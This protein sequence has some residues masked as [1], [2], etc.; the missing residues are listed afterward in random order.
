[1]RGSS[2]YALDF[3]KCTPVLKIGRLC[4]ECHELFEGRQGNGPAADGA[5]Q[6]GEGLVLTSYTLIFTTFPRRVKV[7]VEF[8]EPFRGALRQ[9]RPFTDGIAVNDLEGARARVVLTEIKVF[10]PKSRILWRFKIAS[11]SRLE[12]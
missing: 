10:Q 11:D 2:F 6:F 1:M 3:Q 12:L 7:R 4:Q 8:R 5:E 9:E